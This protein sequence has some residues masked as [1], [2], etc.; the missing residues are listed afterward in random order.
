A[1]QGR[2]KTGYRFTTGAAGKRTGCGNPR[3][4]ALRQPQARDE[5]VWA[6]APLADRLQ[7]GRNALETEP[8][9]DQMLILA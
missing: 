6:T 2:A 4:W 3:Q 1:A 7:G 9:P 8:E 5:G